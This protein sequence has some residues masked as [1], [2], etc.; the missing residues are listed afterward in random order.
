MKN[1]DLWVLAGGGGGRGASGSEEVDVEVRGGKISA[2]Q[3]P[4]RRQGSGRVLDLRG[5]MILPGLINAHDHLE[6]NLFP[7]LGRGPYK[8]AGAWARDIYRPAESPLQEHLRVP[9][10]TRLVWGGIKNL[11]S[12]V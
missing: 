7:R 1:A 2:L 8:N 11:L 3:Q 9:L 5:C 4:R 10:R 6:L 12:G